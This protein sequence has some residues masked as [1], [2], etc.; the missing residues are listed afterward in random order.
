MQLQQ[1]SCF[2]YLH[3]L[4]DVVNGKQRHLAHKVANE[5]LLYYGYILG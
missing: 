4:N 3:L 1:G 5:N 2:N